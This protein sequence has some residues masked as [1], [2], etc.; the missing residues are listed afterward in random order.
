M[1][2]NAPPPPSSAQRIFIEMLGMLLPLVLIGAVALTLGSSWQ[3]GRTL[4]ST[5]E[6]RTTQILAA[7]ILLQSVTCLCAVT[8][9]VLIL[10]EGRRL[11]VAL[12]GRSEPPGSVGASGT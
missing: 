2:A 9:C 8:V 11:R 3:M 12:T 7:I 5:A 6:D 4:A 10:V 1:P